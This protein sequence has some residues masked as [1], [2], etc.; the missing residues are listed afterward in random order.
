MTTFR[1]K[2]EPRKQAAK[3]LGQNLVELAWLFFVAAQWLIVIAV[4]IAIFIGII[5]TIFQ[6]SG[7]SQVI[8]HHDDLFSTEGK[9]FSFLMAIIYI[10]FAFYY[11]FKMR[12][13]PEPKISVKFSIL[14][15]YITVLLTLTYKIESCEYKYILKNIR[16]SETTVHV[17]DAKT[18]LPLQ[19]VT[20]EQYHSSPS[21]KLSLFPRK[22]STSFQPDG[23]FQ[24][25]LIDVQPQ[26]MGFSKTGY[27]TKRIL[28]G[29]EEGEEIL[30]LYLE[31]EADNDPNSIPEKSGD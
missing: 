22:E 25:K 18:K 23:S 3:D 17:L 28:L 26:E 30:K 20:V 6:N 12:K 2:L 13:Q 1:E 15:L 7:S 27:Q 31:K 11:F 4:P 19:D 24:F 21:G 5:A 10:S 29:Q 9:I 14:T 16:Y 8:Q